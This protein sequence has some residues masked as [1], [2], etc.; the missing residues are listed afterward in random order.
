M[1]SCSNE[2]R[3]IVGS[4]SREAQSRLLELALGAASHRVVY[5]RPQYAEALPSHLPAPLAEY[6]AKAVCYSVFAGVK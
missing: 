2:S 6:N 5:K 4:S 3:D 1:A